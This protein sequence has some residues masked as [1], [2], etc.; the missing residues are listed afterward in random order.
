MF[1]LP[2]N[3]VLRK[4]RDLSDDVELFCDGRDLTPKLRDHRVHSVLFSNIP[5]FS[6]GTRPWNHSMGEQRIDDGLIEVIGLTT[7]TLPKLLAGGKGICIAQCKHAVVR[8]SKTIPMQVDGEARRLNPATIELSLL[9]QVRM[10]SKRKDACP[11]VKRHSFSAAEDQPGSMEGDQP[12]RLLVAKILMR[13]YAANHLDKERL[14]QLA[15]PF[16]EVNTTCSADLEQVRA[17]VSDVLESG[18][19]AAAAAGTRKSS[20]SDSG[21]GV[22]KLE[23][24]VSGEEAAAGKVRSDWVF[25]DSVTAMRFFR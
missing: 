21:G 10:L 17:I 20:S 16:G 13:D 12:L 8:T 5:Y 9:N 14:K 25:I 6:S 19:A 22:R 15:I 2:Q 3:L 18:E 23:R 1:V 7:N 24:V 11:K 4:W